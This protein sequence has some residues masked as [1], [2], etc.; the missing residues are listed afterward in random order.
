MTAGA[1]QRIVLATF[2]SPGDLRPFLAIGAELGQRGHRPV[3]ATSAFY[4]EQVAAAGLAFAP[5]RPDRVAG[6]RDPDYLDRIIRGHRSPAAVFRDMF[7]PSL[8]DSL[9]DTLCATE[10]ADAIVA[11][12]LASMAR[13][14]AEVWQIPW[15]SAVM[16]PMGYLS[17]HEPPVVGPPWLASALRG[18]GPR[19]ARYALAA[20]RR[21]TDAWASEWRALRCELGLPGTSDHP[22]WEGQHSPLRSLGL[23]PRVLG[24]PQADW[25]PQARVTGFPFYSVGATLEPRLERFLADGE[26]PLVFTLGT[27]A[28]NDPGAFFAESAL[29]ARRL[30][31]RAVLLVG[32]DGARQGDDVSAGIMAVPYAPHELVFPRAAA[33][34][35]QGGIGT[36]AEAL[37]AGKPMLIM[38]Y[39]HDQQDNAWRA[40]R[41]GVARVLARR[42][43]RAANVSRE[44]A[45]IAANPDARA[46]AA[47]AACAVARE[48]GAA[49]AADMIDAALAAAGR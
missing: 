47:R 38:P 17:A 31:R 26:P 45:G 42:E 43:Y 12:P 7:L 25:P 5:V 48:R 16:Q 22:L 28:V 13:L 1:S 21:L 24:A 33:I 9:A 2:G 3:I 27:T 6:Q 46:A 23:F 41:L 20:A 30:G 35:H 40:R 32:Q 39:G 44:L 36:L 37:R 15:V 49:T 8:R 10:G 18:F 11:H 19:P 14:A 4:R 34:V 29:A